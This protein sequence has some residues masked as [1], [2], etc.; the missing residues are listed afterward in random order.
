[1]YRSVVAKPQLPVRAIL[2]VMEKDSVGV[3]VQVSAH[4]DEMHVQARPKNLVCVQ[5]VRVDLWRVPSKEL[6]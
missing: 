3:I 6:G 5:N 2:L 4:E 1:M